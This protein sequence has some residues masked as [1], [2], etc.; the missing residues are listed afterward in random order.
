M[1]WIFRK[2]KI[3]SQY[4]DLSLQFFSKLR[5]IKKM[6]FS[7]FFKI[8]LELSKNLDHLDTKVKLDNC[9]IAVDQ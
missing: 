5:N 1:A 3:T 7:D 8:L 6:N 2:I 9:I 4:S